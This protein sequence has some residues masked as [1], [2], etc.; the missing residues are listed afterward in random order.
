MKLLYQSAPLRAQWTMWKIKTKRVKT[1]TVAKD[2]ATGEEPL[3]LRPKLE[4]E[5]EPER[6]PE[7]ESEHCSAVRRICRANSSSRTTFSKRQFLWEY[8]FKKW[9]QKITRKDG[10]AEMAWSR[11]WRNWRHRSEEY[12]SHMGEHA[13]SGQITCHAFSHRWILVLNLQ[14]YVLHLKYPLRLEN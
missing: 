13:C 11:E 2:P 12:E 3:S 9:S 5:P 6:E 1:E 4:L 7:S 14:I 10:R 8:A